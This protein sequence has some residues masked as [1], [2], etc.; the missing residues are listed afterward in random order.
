V[1]PEALRRGKEFHRLVQAAWSGEIEGAQVR[2]EHSI[3][4]HAV[5]NVSSHRRRGRMDIFVDQVDDFVSIVEIKSTD[6]DR[7]AKANRPRLLAAHCRQV[8]RYVDK[9]LDHDHVA[10]CAA[11]IYPQAPSSAEVESEVERSLNAHGLQVAWYAERVD[12]TRA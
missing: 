2:A 6:W 9:Y 11:I 10:V 12:C 7:I 8:L 4:L 5:S 1:E 3:F